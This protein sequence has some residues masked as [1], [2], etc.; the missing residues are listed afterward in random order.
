MEKKTQSYMSCLSFHLK[1]CKVFKQLGL[2]M[3]FVYVYECKGIFMFKLIFNMKG[4]SLKFIHFNE[5]CK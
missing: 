2:N 4:N 5:K 3:H 1:Y